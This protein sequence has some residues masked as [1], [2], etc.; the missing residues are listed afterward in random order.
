MVATS[1]VFVRRNVEIARES[2]PKCLKTERPKINIRDII[3]RN[4]S[5]SMIETM[6]QEI[7]SESDNVYYVLLCRF[8]TTFVVARVFV[9]S[10]VS[11]LSRGNASPQRVDA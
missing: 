4:Q 10:V 7:S 3:G 5:R 8:C 11:R 1:V 9:D 2:V 6:N